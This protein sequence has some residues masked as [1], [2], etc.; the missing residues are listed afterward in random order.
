MFRAAVFAAATVAVLWP[1]IAHA[2]SCAMP[3]AS[4]F[5]IDTLANNATGDLYEGSSANG[6]ES[7]NY[8]V[9]QMAIAKNGK[10]FIA[11]MCSGQIRVYR[12]GIGG[13]ATATVRAGSVPTRCDNEDGLLGIVL[14]PNF[15]TNRWLYVFH[16]DINSATS[17]QNADTGKAHLLTRYTYDSTAAAGSQLTNPKL[18]LRMER[19]IDT[20]AYHA[21]GGLDMSANG[22]LVIGTGDDTS[23]HSNECSSNNSAPLLWNSRKCD[24]QKSSANTASLRGKI[25]RIA[26]IPFADNQTPAPGI[27]STYNIPAGNMWEL[28]NNPSFNPNWNSA[29]DDINKVR[30]EIYTMGHRNPYHPR[31]DTKSG[32]IFTGEVGLD[33][34]STTAY[35][36]TRGPEGREEWNLATAPGNYGHPY[37]VGNNTPWRKFTSPA[38]TWNAG[39]GDTAFYNCAAIQ[40]VSPNNYGIVNL[41]P[42]RA[43]SLWYS[44]ANS[45]DDGSRLGFTSGETAVGG[46]MYRYDSTLV[47]P[48]KFPPQYEGKV[49]FFDWANENK[50][51]FRVVTL[52]PNGTI[53][54]GAAAT[55]R[56]PGSTLSALPTGSYIDMQFGPHDGAMYLIKGSN[57]YN[58]F[59]QAALYRVSYTG[60]INNACYS[61]FVATVGPVSIARESIRRTL[62][63]S[64]AVINGMV[65]LPIGYTKVAL[66]DMGGRKV[67][68]HARTNALTAETVRLPDGIAAGVLQARLTR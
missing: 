24:A 48:I 16:T 26:P 39:T 61:P 2:Q 41:P 66:Y 21:A 20:R 32:W 57:T 59:N 15:M 8:G 22:I 31:I 47:S 42:A 11:K 56:F 49:F 17:P 53:D 12:P 36:P 46:P 63:P 6:G 28:I 67:W 3:T 4:D 1:S 68:S 37:C 29:V 30:R 34:G 62:A 35:T 44:N 18:I 52:Q 25:L 5:R 9:V 13:A 50:S 58:N 55:P 38:T 54:T 19:M 60:T 65:T 64:I 51:S 23:P 10:V 7:G 43:A 33:A 27:G 14:D 45:T 40:N